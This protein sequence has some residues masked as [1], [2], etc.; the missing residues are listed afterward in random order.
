MD[1]SLSLT[2]RIERE[3]NGLRGGDDRARARLIELAD[4]RLRALCATMLHRVPRVDRWEETGDIF[5][6]AAARLYRSLE[7]VKPQSP[8]HFFRL[9][10]LQIRRVLIDLARRYGGPEGLGA[11]HG[12]VN[13]SQFARIEP[14]G[15][16]EEP[17]SLAEWTEFHDQVQA[18]PE[19]EREVLDL[20][21]Y[22]GLSQAEAAELL[23]ISER[24]IKRRWQDAK[25]A[26][27]RQLI[28]RPI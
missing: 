22:H 20:L 11:N 3:L 1:T 13:A 9:A 24:T 18:L 27:R 23:G 21:W 16:A 8:R 19:A 26:L 12:T 5:S 14:R 2:G 28:A 15:P 4:K 7:T 10:A 6:E 17:H 25:L